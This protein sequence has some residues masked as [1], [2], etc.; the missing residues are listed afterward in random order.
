MRARLAL[1]ALS[2]TGPLALLA[3]CG[4]PE[5]VTQSGLPYADANRICR[6]VAKRFQEVQRD[7]PRSFEQGEQLLSVLSDAAEK[8][9]RALEQV[10]APPLQTIA[11]ERY[12]K[13]RARV[14]KLLEKGLQAARDEEGQAYEEARVAANSAAD[15]RRRLARY[16]GLSDCAGAER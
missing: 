6:E 13:S 7:S 11:F 5:P 14:G 15:Q 2:V 12:L 4:D 16:A 8:G 9:A 10:D 1:L 3:G